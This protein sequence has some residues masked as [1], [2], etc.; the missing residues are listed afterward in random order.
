MMWRKRVHM[1]T[2][3]ESI[4]EPILIKFNNEECYKKLSNNFGFL[5]EQS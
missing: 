4:E 2:T 5:L 1:R 3:R